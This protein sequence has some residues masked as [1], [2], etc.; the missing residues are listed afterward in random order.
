MPH[1]YSPTLRSVVLIRIA[2]GLIFASE[3]IQKFL[4]A[5]T[6]GAERF[7]KIG[8]PFPHLTGPCVGGVEVIC[9]IFVLVCLATRLAAMPLIVEMLVA[10][11]STKIPI[12]L[13][14]GYG[15]FSHTFAPKA[16]P[17][18]FLHESRT[19]IAMLCCAAFLAIM[20]AGP[21]SLDQRIVS[22]PPCVRE[23]VASR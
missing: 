15:I 13:G 23:V 10:L 1:L 3:G 18:S 22:N 8:I 4:D 12:L 9:G 5:D 11:A 19:D 7:S 21:W 6:H 2:V 14:R 17:W 20:G 16:G